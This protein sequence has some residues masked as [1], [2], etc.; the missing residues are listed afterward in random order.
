MQIDLLVVILTLCMWVLSLA[1][2]VRVECI[3]LLLRLR[4]MSPRLCSV[5]ISRLLLYL[6]NTVL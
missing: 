1:R 5:L 3:I 4:C 2:K 6:G